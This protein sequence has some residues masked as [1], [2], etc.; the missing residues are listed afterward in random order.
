MVVTGSNR[1]ISLP[2]HFP[3]YSF[4]G[5]LLR[6]TPVSCQLRHTTASQLSEL[7]ILKLLFSVQ[8]LP[9]LQSHA[10][11]FQKHKLRADQVSL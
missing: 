9:R 1:G 10:L 5:L 6:G 8:E 7:R 4:L 11:E 3:I 2:T